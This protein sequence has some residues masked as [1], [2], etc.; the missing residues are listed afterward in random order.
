[1]RN[2]GR[3]LTEMLAE[4][5][6][7]EDRGRGERRWKEGTRKRRRRRGHNLGEQ[8][9]ERGKRSRGRRGEEEEEGEV[10]QR[11]GR[12]WKRAL[13][14]YMPMWGPSRKAAD[15]QTGKEPVPETALART[16]AWECEKT[17]V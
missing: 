8:Q 7:G 14:F 10:K 4:G 16:V 9:E 3:A 13:S 1:M 5:E 2:K 17:S 11:R 12:L 15:C 6:S